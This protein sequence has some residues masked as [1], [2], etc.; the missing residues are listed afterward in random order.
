MA[1]IIIY[2]RSNNVYLIEDMLASSPE[3]PDSP[4]GGG[5]YWPGGGGWY[6]PGGDGW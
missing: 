5:W 2:I 6:C 1:F 3:P 4:G